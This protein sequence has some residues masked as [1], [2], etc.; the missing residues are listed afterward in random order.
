MPFLKYRNVSTTGQ[1]LPP[2]L[3]L[4]T[5]HVLPPPAHHEHA[6]T[7]TGDP[8]GAIGVEAMVGLSPPDHHQRQRE[9]RPAQC[10]RD[11]ASDARRVVRHGGENNGD[12]VVEACAN[13]L[14]TAGIAIM[15]CRMTMTFEIP[16]E[17][18]TGVA[19]IPD[20]DVR[21]A[22]YLR[23]E[24]QLEILRRQRHSAEAR[25]IAERAVLQAERDQ[26]AGFDW[27]AS[28]DTLKQQ[29]QTITSKL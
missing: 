9:V 3:L 11:A 21:V 16:S 19:G 22:L 2:L 17:V 20:L 26:S 12:D 24:A 10:R 1:V 5:V 28:F 18:H 6:G 4:R 25:S 7:D 23:H 8:G 15:L 13:G 27:N 29:H 14:A